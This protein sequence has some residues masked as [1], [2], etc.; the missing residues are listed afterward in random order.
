M[1][2]WVTK[3]ALTQGI[4]EKEGDICT[5]I[6][7]QMISCGPLEIYHGE[8]KEWHRTIESAIKKSENM[9][10]SKISSFKKK[11]EKLNKLTFKTK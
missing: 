3:Y 8:G 10:I 5:D 11:I 9:R 1:K 6:N 2:I 7:V 4:L